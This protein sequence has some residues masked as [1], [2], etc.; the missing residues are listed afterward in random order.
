MDLHFEK[1]HPDKPNLSAGEKLSIQLA[2]FTEAIEDARKQSIRNVYFIVGKGEGILKTE[3]QKLAKHQKIA[4]S[5][6]YEP[7]YFGNAIKVNL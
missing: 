3:I 7:P 5:V 4:H 1:L 2:A 6:N